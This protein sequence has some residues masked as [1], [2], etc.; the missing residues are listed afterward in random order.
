M[1]KQDFEQIREYLVWDGNASPLT[2]FQTGQLSIVDPAEFPESHISE[3]MALLTQKLFEVLRFHDDQDR[4]E[5]ATAQLVAHRLASLFSI[6]LTTDRSCS[7]ALLARWAVKEAESHD[8]CDVREAREWY[9][10]AFDL[11]RV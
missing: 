4:R 8:S 9:L 3:Y 10:Q 7:A 6:P 2:D 5:Y 1:I 11:F